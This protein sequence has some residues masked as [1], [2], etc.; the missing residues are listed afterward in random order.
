MKRT[1]L[2]FTFILLNPFLFF[3]GIDAKL[4]VGVVF[5]GCGI[6]DGTEVSEAVLTM[7]YLEKA[8]ADVI[9]MAP[10]IKQ[11]EVVNHLNPDQKTS[12]DRNVLVESA[13][14]TRGQIKDIKQVK[15][16]DIDALIIVGGLGSIKTLSNIM[17]KGVK[18]I[19]NSDL[20]KLIKEVYKFKKPIGSMCAASMITAKVLGKN[21]IKITI[22]TKNDYFGPMITTFGAEHIEC[23]VDDIVVD[24]K[25]KIV[26]TP[27]FMLG[28][29]TSDIAPGIEKFVNKL[30]QLAKKK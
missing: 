17:T 9:Y 22:G 2:F 25:N 21:K 28:P 11:A 14:I 5:S 20:E 15:A 19:V 6:Q 30:V 26:T 24:N 7:L 4:R 3:S 18:G 27:A 12:E 29:S 8:N 10:D 1:L 13:R 16:Q 23:T